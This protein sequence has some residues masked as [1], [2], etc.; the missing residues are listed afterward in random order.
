MPSPSDMGIVMMG[1]RT[2]SREVFCACQLKKLCSHHRVRVL[3]T[4]H[5]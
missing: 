2:V 1:H 3:M 5:Q 4:I